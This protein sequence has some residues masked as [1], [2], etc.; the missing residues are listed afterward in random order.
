MK[1]KPMYIVRGRQGERIT[2][3]MIAKPKSGNRQAFVGMF[4]PMKMVQHEPGM[5]RKLQTIL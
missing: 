5:S 2:N 3:K 1:M 4:L